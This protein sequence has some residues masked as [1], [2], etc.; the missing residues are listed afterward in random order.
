MSSS[1]LVSSQCQRAGTQSVG[2]E[3]VSRRAKSITLIYDRAGRRIRNARMYQMK[4]VPLRTATEAKRPDF[5]ARLKRI[6]GSKKLRVNG[7]QLWRRSVPDR[8]VDRS[9]VRYVP[10]E[11]A[12]RRSS[13][14]S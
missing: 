11:L 3:R 4:R 13:F 10:G 7:A 5:L 8:K 12:H 6:Y 2:R 1:V 9:Q 14:C